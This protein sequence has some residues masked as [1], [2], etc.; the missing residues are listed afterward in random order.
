M[1]DSKKEAAAIAVVKTIIELSEDLSTVAT[2][3]SPLPNSWAT[4]GKQM[5]MADRST[6]QLRKNRGK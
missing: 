3:K 6:M 1:T 5:I 4:Q 2:Q